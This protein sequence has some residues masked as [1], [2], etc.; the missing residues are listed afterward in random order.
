MSCYFW[1]ITLGGALANSWSGIHWPI[2]NQVVVNYHILFA[3]SS[4]LRLLAAFLV[5]TF[6]EP[7]EKGIPVLIDFMGYSI[8]RWISLGRELFPHLLKKDKNN[9]DDPGENDGI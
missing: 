3:I 6:H 8:L 4:L 2:G 9:N 1:D 7:K 5:L